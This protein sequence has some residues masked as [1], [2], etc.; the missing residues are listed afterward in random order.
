MILPGPGLFTLYSLPGMPD[1]VGRQVG[2]PGNQSGIPM[3]R[4]CSAGWMGWDCG[5]AGNSFQ[6]RGGRG[7]DQGRAAIQFW[8][9]RKQIAALSQPWPCLPTHDTVL[10]AWPSVPWLWGFWTG[11]HGDP[12]CPPIPT[13]APGSVHG[14]N[15]LGCLGSGVGSGS[16]SQRELLL[17]ELSS[18][19]ATPVLTYA[20]GWQD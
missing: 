13:G 7:Q 10:S 9:Y 2:S 8:M 18:F 17:W 20:P 14:A 5:W 16:C 12:A 19:C 1:G 11:L 15:S 6:E 3:D 4:V